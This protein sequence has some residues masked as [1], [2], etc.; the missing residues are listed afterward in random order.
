MSGDAE[1]NLRANARDLGKTPLA[2][3]PRR[4]ERACFLLINTNRSYRL[5]SGQAPIN[6]GVKV[7][8]MFKSFGYEVFFM[9]NPHLIMFTEYF[10]LFL[11]RTTEHL[12]FAKIGDGGE[13]GDQSIIFD[14]EPL[15][16]TQFIQLVSDNK[17]AGL[18]MTI[19]S[20]FSNEKSVFEQLDSFD[21]N[22]VLIACIGDESQILEGPEKLI[23]QFTREVTNR[24]QISNQ[25]LYDSLRIVIKRSGLRLS[26]L[27]S[28]D[29]LAK[30]VAIYRP[31]VERNE[32]IH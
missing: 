26:V 21:Q 30:P 22:T 8:E 32:L 13:P 10:S 23:T 4:I 3:I 9:L 2:R 20:D 6:R 18:E 28:A 7:A 19:L 29:S 5:N 16:D 31:T 11:Q 14:D 12:F 1:R 24:N 27:G 17:S 25:Q 15:E